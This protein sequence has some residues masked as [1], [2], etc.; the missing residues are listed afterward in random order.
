MVPA[1]AVTVI[2]WKLACPG[3]SEPRFQDTTPLVT[4]LPPVAETSVVLAGTGMSSSVLSVLL[5][6]LP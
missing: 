5:P 3:A 4:L 2:C 6:L 1:G